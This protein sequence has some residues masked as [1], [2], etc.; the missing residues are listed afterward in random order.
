MLYLHSTW[1]CSKK[2]SASGKWTRDDHFEGHRLSRSCLKAQD[3]ISTISSEHV[4]IVEG[5]LDA[6]NIRIMAPPISLVN[7]VYLPLA[8]LIKRRQQHLHTAD[9]YEMSIVGIVKLTVQLG[10]YRTKHKLLVVEELLMPVNLGVDFLSKHAVTLI[11]DQSLV[12][13]YRK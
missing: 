2:S 13:S 8:C 11:F 6:S 3:F 12:C 7:K 10:S 5:K 1:T 4:P 9:G